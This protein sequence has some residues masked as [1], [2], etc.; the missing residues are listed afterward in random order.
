MLAAQAATALGF[1]LEW[2]AD[3]GPIRHRASSGETG[4]TRAR[5]ERL[6]RTSDGG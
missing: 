6:P 5:G 4:A 2:A 3:R 1:V